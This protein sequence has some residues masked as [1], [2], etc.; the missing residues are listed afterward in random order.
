MHI[1]ISCCFENCLLSDIC[2]KGH[3][4][5]CTPV[6]Y[7]TDRS[8]AVDPV[9]FLFF[10]ALWF[11][12]RGTSCFKVF[13]CSLSSCFF[14]FIPFSIVFTSLGEEGAGLCV[15]CAIV[16]FV[17]VGFCHFSLPLGVRVRLRFLIVALPA[18]FY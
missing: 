16:C 4:L 1:L 12:L 11:I 15:S 2:I 5:V 18:L 14:F 6:V 10:V 9:L 13:P 7:A 17:R 8:K 3:N